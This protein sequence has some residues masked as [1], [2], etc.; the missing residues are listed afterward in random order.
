MSHTAEAAAAAATDN[1]RRDST[2]LSH[3]IANLMYLGAM[4][5]QQQDL[6]PTRRYADALVFER[7]GFVTR[8]IGSD[9]KRCLHLRNT[10]C[11]EL[12]YS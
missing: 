7:T 5:R 9:N 12:S 2:H 4:S 6:Q 8:L 10:V 3:L 1:Q 11:L